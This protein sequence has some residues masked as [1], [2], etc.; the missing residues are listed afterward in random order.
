MSVLDKTIKNWPLFCWKQKRIVQIFEVLPKINHSYI[1]NRFIF[2]PLSPFLLLIQGSL[3]GYSTIFRC[4]KEN[5]VF[6]N[7]H[8][9]RLAELRLWSHF[10]W[11]LIPEGTFKYSIN[12][13]HW[14]NYT[15]VNLWPKSINDPKK[16]STR[17]PLNNKK[18]KIK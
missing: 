8:I 6:T 17:I 18:K 16:A 2:L 12:N 10:T 15:L 11:F 7:G 1:L 5:K 4:S 13:S 3:Q 14:I 9:F